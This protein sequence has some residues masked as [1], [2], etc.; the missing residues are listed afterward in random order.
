M[1][2][3]VIPGYPRP[4]KLL[5]C[6][7]PLHL[8]HVNGS[9]HPAKEMLFGAVGSDGQWLE[10]IWVGGT[11]GTSGYREILNKVLAWADQVY[12]RGIYV[13]QQ[14]GAPSHASKATLSQAKLFCTTS[15]GQRDS[16]QRKCGLHPAPTWIRWTSAC[17]CEWRKRPAA[18][19]TQ[20]PQLWRPL[21]R[22]CGPPSQRRHSRMPSMPSAPALRHALRPMVKF[23]K[24]NNDFRQIWKKI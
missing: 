10:L 16:G 12:G 2:P 1:Q 7:N 21:S 5:L 20:M 6:Y 23:L 24:N 13:Y 19:A 22:R 8:R 15:W 3:P 18:T 17:G 4:Q 9:K 14:D 11:L